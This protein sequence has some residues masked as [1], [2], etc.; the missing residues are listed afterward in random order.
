MTTTFSKVFGI[1]TDQLI[2]IVGP[3]GNVAEI[4]DNGRLLVTD[5][6][7]GTTLLTEYS[8]ELLYPMSNTDEQLLLELDNTEP[9]EL[10]S[11]A[12]DWSYLSSSNRITVRVYYKVGSDFI[13]VDSAKFR[14]SSNEGCMLRDMGGLYSPMRITVQIDNSELLDR[15]IKFRYI[16]GTYDTSTT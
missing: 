12:I 7:S 2:H 4:D 13:V 6:G 3:D 11:F 16:V 8:G 1:V 15:S 10:R 9:Y 14:V 5:G